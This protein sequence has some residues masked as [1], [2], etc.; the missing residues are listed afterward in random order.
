MIRV[1]I[2]VGHTVAH[3]GAVHQGTNLKEH[4]VCLRYREVLFALLKHDRRFDVVEVLPGISLRSRIT[5]VNSTH[6]DDPIDLAIE[7]HM[8]AFRSPGPNYTEVYHFA[9]PNG[10]SSVRGKAYGDAFLTPLVGELGYGD[11]KRDGLSEPFGD[12]AEERE[13]YGFVRGCVPPALVIEPAFIS[14]DAVVTGIIEHGL[15]P[16]MASGCYR[17]LVV[18][19][20][21]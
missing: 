12:T 2:S 3:P 20:E 6:K 4:D 1:S 9:Y 14:N 15:V 8:N 7:L 13:H 16:S 19:L 17:G 11:G 18:C 5:A 10:T 21:V